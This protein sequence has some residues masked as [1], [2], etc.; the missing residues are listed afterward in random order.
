[1]DFLSVS[2]RQRPRLRVFPV[3]TG[4]DP[5]TG[6]AMDGYAQP[7]GFYRLHPLSVE[8]VQN[9]FKIFSFNLFSAFVSLSTLKANSSHYP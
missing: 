9:M 5:M 1:M 4:L 8:Q 6:P 7:P 3:S 2:Q